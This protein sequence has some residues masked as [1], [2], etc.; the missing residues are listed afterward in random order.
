MPSLNPPQLGKHLS[1]A[2]V[3]GGI[4]GLLDKHLRDV[5]QA[6][7][8]ALVWADSLRVYQPYTAASPLVVPVDWVTPTLGNSWANA[9]G[10]NASAQ[11]KIDT[12]GRVTIRGLITGGT[13]NNPAFTLPTGYRPSVNETFASSANG[14]FANM[15]VA[16]DGRVIPQIGS[17]TNFSIECAFFADATSN[18]P[19]PPGCFPVT[20]G[21]WPFSAPPTGVLASAVDVTTNSGTAANLALSAAD[22][23]YAAAPGNQWL[24]T[25]RNL[26][27]LLPSRKYALTAV[28]F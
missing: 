2:G 5:A 24:L 21:L 11:Y 22:W 1:D 27:G 23:T 15:A 16:S 12:L 28:A 17:N 19:I 4:A 20:L 6:A 13:L 18:A 8:K 26:P 25:L 7:N 14:A 9:G 3:P 10:G